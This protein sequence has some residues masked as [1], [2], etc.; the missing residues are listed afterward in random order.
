MEGYRR[1]LDFFSALPD[2]EEEEVVLRKMAE[3]T[4]SLLDAERATIFLL[5]EDMSRLS[6]EAALGI[7]SSGF[8]IEKIHGIAGYTLQTGEKVILDDAYEDERFYKEIDKKTGFR[9]KSVLCVPIS[10]RDG[11]RIGVVEV[12]NSRRGKF[13]SEEIPL[14]EAVAKQV[15]VVVLGMRRYR[16]L[17]ETTSRLQKEKSGL[18]EHLKRRF[19]VEA[20]I[21]VSDSIRRLRQTILKVADTDSTVLVSGETGT[22]KELV[23]RAL[24]YESGRAAAEFVVVNCAAVA[25]TLLEAELFGVERGVATGVEERPGKIEVADGGTLFLDEV[26][27]M[28]APMQA[29]L[30]RVLQEKAVIRVGS[31]V[32]RKVNVR[33]VAA[34]NKRLPEMMKRGEFREDLYYRL[35][36]IE[37]KTPPLRERVEDIEPLALHFLSEAAERNNK[38]VV[39]I[40]EDAVEFLKKQRWE[41]NVRQLRNAVESAVVLT[42]SERLGVEDFSPFFGPPEYRTPPFGLNLKE[43]RERLEEMLVA[44]ALRRTGGHRQK[45]AKLLGISREALRKKMRKFGMEDEWA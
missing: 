22:G 36:I 19:G 11:S 45:A 39:G 12:L 43:Q 31:A 10:R 20:I 14:L 34:T 26:G 28:S 9:T 25:D 30:L 27:D 24:H 2:D 37:I 29:K 21:G 17:K 18:L 32:E 42:E 13:S 1:I 8:H 6:A 33:F 23:A 3:F 5:T 15:G 7:D 16:Y 38:R 41:G 40:T 44:E 35:R 4:A